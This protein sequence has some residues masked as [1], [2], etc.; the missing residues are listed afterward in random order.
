M[1]LMIKF[2]GENGKQGVESSTQQIEIATK[3]F[4][5]VTSPLI[6]CGADNDIPGQHNVQFS[7][8]ILKRTSCSEPIEVYKEGGEGGGCNG[9]SLI[10]NSWNKGNSADVS[11]LLPIPVKYFSNPFERFCIFSNVQIQGV[12]ENYVEQCKQYNH[13]MKNSDKDGSPDIQ[14]VGSYFPFFFGIS[15]IIF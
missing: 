2:R 13:K 3:D 11:I 15:Y 9:S 4:V 1:I 8:L 12:S 7:V 5:R 6:F 14:G 10:D